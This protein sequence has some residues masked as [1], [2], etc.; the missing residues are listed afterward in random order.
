MDITELERKFKERKWKLTRPRRAIL[1]VLSRAGS[2]LNPAQIYRLG[3]RRYRRLGLVTVY[4]T[5]A[6]LEELGLVQRVHLETGCH[7]FAAVRAPEGHHHQLIC[8]DCGRVEEFSE[9][10]S[11][12]LL[13]QLQHRTGFVIETHYL[14][15][16][17]YCPKCQ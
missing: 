15:V 12:Q 2:H 5:L 17:G 6:L 13:A 10:G 3:R 8:K 11:D 1:E 9:C 14:E 4:R 16:I 7:G